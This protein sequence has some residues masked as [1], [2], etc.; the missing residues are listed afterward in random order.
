MTMAD[1]AVRAPAR[2]AFFWFSFGYRYQENHY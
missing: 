1:A 2:G